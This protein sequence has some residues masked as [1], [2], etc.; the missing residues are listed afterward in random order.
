VNGQKS[1][2]PSLH[3][4]IYGVGGRP[5]GPIVIE[6]L[7]DAVLRYFYGSLDSRYRDCVF[8]GRD[9]P[10]EAESVWGQFVEPYLSSQ[11]R[12]FTDKVVGPRSVYTGDRLWPDFRELEEAGSRVV[13]VFCRAGSW[14]RPSH[15]GIP[16]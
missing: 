16:R 10:I 12:T 8:V 7:L 2:N 1:L 5:E 14:A 3:Y 15:S 4:R 13:A 6:G 11:I 9:D